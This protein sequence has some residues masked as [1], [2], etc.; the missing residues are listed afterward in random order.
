MRLIKQSGSLLAAIGFLAVPAVAGVKADLHILGFSS[1]GR[2]FAFEDSGYYDAIEGY[3]SKIQIV[4]AASDTLAH[5]PFSTSHPNELAKTPTVPLETT[6]AE[7]IKKATPTLRALGV[8]LN[9]TGE[10][11]KISFPDN[12]HRKGQFK[13][14]GTAYELRLS[15]KDFPSPECYLGEQHSL[16]FK[17]IL[18][19]AH[20][21]RTLHDDDHVPR[22]RG[23]KGCVLG[24]TLGKVYA[25]GKYLVVI[26]DTRVPGFEGDS[27]D[28]LAVTAKLK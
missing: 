18:A 7:N 14:S 27:L 20:G 12:D 17:L 22:S 1:D 24:Y 16:G 4:D 13:L 8:K 19:E 5:A 25:K 6:R 10:A 9:D 2:Y 26:L 11:P 23:D 3:W 15:T 21:Q 28:H